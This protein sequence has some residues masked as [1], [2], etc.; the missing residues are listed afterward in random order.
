MFVEH[1]PPYRAYSPSV[2]TQYEPSIWNEPVELASP[3]NKRPESL[4]FAQGAQSQL[5]ENKP[6]PDTL[7]SQPQKAPTRRPSLTQKDTED[8]LFQEQQSERKQLSPKISPEPQLE[9]NLM[10][11]SAPPPVRAPTPGRAL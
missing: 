1:Q 8:T 10:T 6:T 2:S 3:Y 11:C 9:V 4:I 7:L 5:V